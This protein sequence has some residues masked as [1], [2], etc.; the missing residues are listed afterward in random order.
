MVDNGIGKRLLLQ[1]IESPSDADIYDGRSEGQLLTE[2]LR[3]SGITPTYNVVVNLTRF[4]AALTHFVDQRQNNPAVIP[5]LHLSMHGTERGILLTDR[6]S[7][8]WTEL[9][10]LLWAAAE[11]HVLL[12]MSTCF[13]FTGCQMA[14]SSE[15]PPF[16]AIVGHPSTVNWDDAAVAYIA[17]YHRMF[18]GATVPQAVEAMREAA[19]TPDFAVI[20]GT[21]A[22][23]LLAD[24]LTQQRAKELMSR[25]QL[26]RQQV[27]ARQRD[28]NQSGAG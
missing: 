4:V 9:R 14:M 7:I 11:G 23:K 6:S 17:F 18:R 26:A 15:K 13:G 20:P 16:L 24:A 27:L 10:N 2:A 5:I 3:L 12:C 19:G 22:Q 25:L 28:F 21:V 8:S 1:I